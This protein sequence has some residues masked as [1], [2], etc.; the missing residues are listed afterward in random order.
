M[1]LEPARR[2]KKLEAQ[3]VGTYV[4][5]DEP[6][7][8]LLDHGDDAKIIGVAIEKEGY[9]YAFLGAEISLTQLHRYKRE[10]VDLRYLFLRP[11]WNKWFIFDLAKANENGS[12]PLKRAEMEDYKNDEHLPSHGFFARNHTEKFDDD[13]VAKLAT[14]KYLIDGSWAPSD[15]SMF[16][17]RINDLYSFF[18]GIKKFLSDGTTQEQ[19]RALVV[20]FTDHPMRGGSSYVG[21]YGDLK[22]LLGFDERLAMGSI[23]KESPG[24]VDVEGKADVLVEVTEALQSY[25]QNADDLEARYKE[26]HSYLSRGKL[27]KAG[28]DRF[29][30]TG[31]VAVYIR[32][33]SRAFA[34]SLAVDYDAID[35]LT[36]KNA[37][38]S[39]KILLS[40]YRRLE[41]Y[42]LFFAEGRVQLPAELDDFFLEG[43]G[44]VSQ[45]PLAPALPTL[46][47][48]EK[49]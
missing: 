16:F 4:Y 19:K 24:Y 12:I 20:A 45:L 42:H 1:K 26:L 39:A 5:L 48:P 2:W 41:R 9:D 11:R 40:H 44:T 6:Q 21:F 3:Y 34:K 15:L 29:D 7:V 47:P 38:L 28:P 43:Q 33:L 46:S 10:F 14:Q 25:E 23:K 32:K 31:P 18:I 13:P 30:K 49:T 17:G 37:L 36:G 35:R 8:V 27:L 22:G